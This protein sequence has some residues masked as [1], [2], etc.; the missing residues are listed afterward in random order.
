MTL[1]A[2]AMTAAV[3]GVVMLV[4]VVMQMLMAVGMLMVM[5]MHM[6]M[7][8][9]MGNTVMGVLMGMGML[10]VMAV[11]MTADVIVIQMHGRF[12]FCF[13]LYYNGGPCGCQNIYFYQNN[14]PQGL[15][16]PGK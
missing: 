11:A 2:A 10:V 3:M 7:L 5:V 4:T 6:A 15:R 16:E 1:A 8:M 13:S 12:S 14:P 9:G